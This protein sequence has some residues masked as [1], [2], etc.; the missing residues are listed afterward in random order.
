MSPPLLVCRTAWMDHY[1]GVTATDT[2]TGG[3]AW[4]KEHGFGHEAFNFK[5]SRRFIRN[6]N[7]AANGRFPTAV[8]DFKYEITH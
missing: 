3:G 8:G 2:P 4:V 6:P 7:M 5:L 1:R